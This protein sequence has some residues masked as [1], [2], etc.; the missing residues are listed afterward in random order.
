M[1][2][3]TLADYQKVVGNEWLPLPDFKVTVRGGWKGEVTAVL[4]RTVVVRDPRVEAEDQCKSLHLKSDVVPDRPAYL[5]WMENREA[6]ISYSPNSARRPP[7]ILVMRVLK[8]RL[9]LPGVLRLCGCGGIAVNRKGPARCQ[10]CRADSAARHREYDRVRHLHRPDGPKTCRFECGRPARNPK[11]NRLVCD[12][13]SEKRK[14]ERQHQAN[15]LKY[16]PCPSCGVPCRGATC[17]RCRRTPKCV[18]CRH[19]YVSREGGTCQRCEE[20]NAA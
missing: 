8:E 11:A 20:E 7:E 14:K 17:L 19:T 4:K 5:R 6:D 13:C 16:R 9:G 2:A 10:E 15:L 12:E 3:L 18:A 1:Q